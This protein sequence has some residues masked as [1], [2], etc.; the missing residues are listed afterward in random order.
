MTSPYEDLGVP[1][2]ASPEAIKA[3]YRKRARATHPDRNKGAGSEPFQRVQR[4]YAL[5]SD[6]QKRAHY[7][8]TG[9]EQGGSDP[10]QVALSTIAGMFLNLIDNGD[11]DHMDLVDRARQSVNTQLA[12]MKAKIAEYAGRIRKREKAIK[13]LKKKAAGPNLI[14]TMIEHD[15]DQNRRAIEAVEQQLLIGKD[16]LE[17]LDEYQYETDPG[18]QRGFPDTGSALF[19][20]LTQ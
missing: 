11:V 17:I 7:D 5:L 1:R 6:P 4:A 15:I 14:A 16:L 3:G 19:R 20:R 8:R 9:E 13:R 12:Q 18:A 10:R 2:D